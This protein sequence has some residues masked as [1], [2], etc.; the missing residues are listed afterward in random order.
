MTAFA[1]TATGSIAEVRAA[2]AA[3]PA[4]DLAFPQGVADL[5]A[6]QLAP[7]PEDKNLTLTVT[8]DAGWAA[9]QIA[10]LISLSVFAAISS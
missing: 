5:I 6:A 7:V 9:E 1:F 4:A 3:R 2:L 10:G 8:G